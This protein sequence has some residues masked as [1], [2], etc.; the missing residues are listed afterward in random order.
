M[1]YKRKNGV[2]GVFYEEYG[3]TIEP[4]T[5]KKQQKN[6][7]QRQKGVK[8][9]KN[10]VYNWKKG[11]KTNCKRELLSRKHLPKRFPD[12]GEISRKSY[13]FWTLKQPNYGEIQSIE[14]EIQS[15]IK[16]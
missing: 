15:D 1:Y 11:V 6:E 3:A 5:P 14:R 13:G 10:R 16:E 7:R 2:E 4:V 8:C 12:V 9:R